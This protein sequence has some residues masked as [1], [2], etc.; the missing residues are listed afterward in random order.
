M[1]KSGCNH[2]AS[3]DKPIVSNGHSVSSLLAGAEVQLHRKPSRSHAV[4]FIAAEGEY[5]LRLPARNDLIATGHPRDVI[6]A[7]EAIRQVR[8]HQTVRAKPGVQTSIG[9]I[10]RAKGKRLRG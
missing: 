6:D 8:G 1:A 10:G 7:V 4:A 2:Y 9:A 3:G 5:S